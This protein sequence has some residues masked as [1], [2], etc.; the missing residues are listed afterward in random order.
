TENTESYIVLEP[1]RNHTNENL[2]RIRRIMQET[3]K[4]K[5]TEEG[6]KK[7][8]MKPLWRSKEYDN[9]ESKVKQK[10]KVVSNITVN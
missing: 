10:L 7:T 8:A 3:Q 4:R 6:A 9:V 1:P 5:S 2:K